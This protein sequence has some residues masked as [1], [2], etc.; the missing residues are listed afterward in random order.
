MALVPFT[1]GHTSLYGR[2][3][4]NVIEDN[5]CWLGTERTGRTRGGYIQINA[6]VPGLGGRVVHFSAHV[7]TWLIAQLDCVL[8][9]IDE[10]YLAYLEVRHSGYEIGHSCHEPACRRPVHLSLLTHKE[11]IAQ[12]D[13]RRS[14]RTAAPE[15]RH[16]SRTKW[17]SE[18][19]GCYVQCNCCGTTL[20]GAQVTRNPE[21]P[22]R[23]SH[24]DG[25]KMR[26]RAAERGWTHYRPDYDYCEVCSPNVGQPAPGVFIVPGGA[27]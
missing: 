1:S 10:I 5:D 23:A 25:G 24:L 17:S 27:S 8:I 15:P 9:D 12:R 20:D 4:A 14:P 3:V 7:L 16:P 6:R 22:L 2:L 11:N 19:H 26:Q 18:M 21:P 13:A